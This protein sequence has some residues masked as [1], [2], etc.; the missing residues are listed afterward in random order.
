MDQPIFRQVALERLSSPEELDRL[1]RV[2]DSKAWIAQLTMLALTAVA[3]AWG[4]YG[5]IP[6]VVSGQGV[7]IRR[8]GVLNIVSAG[9]GVVA[10]LKVKVGDRINEGQIVAEIAQPSM[11]ERRKNA[12]EALA[13]AR[14]EKD[15]SHTIHV[16]QATMERA[17]IERQRANAEMEVKHL[18]QQADLAKEN[19]AA[20]NQLLE[21][22]IIIKQ[23]AIEASQSLAGIQDRIASVQAHIQELQAQEFSIQAR[24][25]EEDAQKEM[26]IQDLERNVRAVENDLEIAGKVVSPYRGEVLEVKVSTGTTVGTSDPILSIQPDV[27]DL[28][29]LLYLPAA[30][31]K[32]VRSG[33]EAR[34]S[35]SSVKPEEFGFVKGYVSYVS[36]FP[37][38][39]AELMHNFQNEVLVKALTS[40]G[41]VTGLRVEMDRNPKTFSGYQWSSSKGPKLALSGGTLCTAEVVTRWQRPLEL[42]LP[43]LRKTLGLA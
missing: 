29:V 31:A 40:E 21:A 32:D 16:E 41:P 12:E 22:G 36:D 19:V 1:L 43:A 11:L 38:T 10:Q 26:A 3:I 34:I 15:R 42:L 27:Q 28:E 6:S 4:Y 17:A 5:R 33:M 24:V 7:I 18:E 9:S 13:Q 23:K 39:T 2:T 14:R 20:Q 35:P 37:D 25:H 30:R 8:G